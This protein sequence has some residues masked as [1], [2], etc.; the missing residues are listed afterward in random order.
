MAREPADTPGGTAGREH[1]WAP[2][3][4][5]ARPFRPSCGAVLKGSESGPWA[6]DGSLGWED[7]A[8]E[9]ARRFAIAALLA[10]GLVACAGGSSG[11]TAPSNAGVAGAHL[12]TP[13]VII[14]ATDQQTFDPAMEK[15]TTG[16]IIEWQNKSSVVH[17]IVF[18]NDVS[19]SDPG[20]ATDSEPALSDASL[21]PGG[22]WQVKFTVAG[23]YNYLCTIHNAMVGTIVVTSG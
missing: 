8:V 22:V 23:T 14:S 7:S 17:N 15:V 13:A 5:I 20:L 16:E 11:P 21:E 3:C 6:I 10:V 4:R 19:V 18:S 2:R 9:G 1:E 12:G